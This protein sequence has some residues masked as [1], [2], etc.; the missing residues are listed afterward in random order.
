MVVAMY[1]P[2]QAVR[3][4]PASLLR[5]VLGVPGV[6]GVFGVLFLTGALATLGGCGDKTTVVQ[7]VV[8]PDAGVVVERV[9]C[10]SDA[11]CD[12][13]LFCD[14]PETC[15]AGVCGAG[16]APVC[17]DGVECTRDRCSEATRACVY[18]AADADADGHADANCQDADGV[19]LGDDCDDGD[20][21]R[22]PGNV[23]V[24][25]AQ[26]HD[27]DCDASTI[28]MRDVDA[29]TY[30]DAMCCNGE[31]C[32]SD[33]D[34]MNPNVHPSQA[35][36]CDGFDNNCDGV[37]DEGLL[38]MM[39]RDA[40]GDHVGDADG[41]FVAVC[42]GTGGY[43][44][45][46]ADCDDG[47]RRV[48]PNINELCSDGVDNDCDGEVDETGP[49]STW[50]R[51][52]DGD[53]FGDDAVQ[54]IVS[55]EVQAG[56]TLFPHDCNDLNPLV[57]PD[58]VEVCNG[59][60]DDCN[61]DADF[62]ISA[63]NGEDD[64]RDG[65]ADFLCGGALPD[66]DDREPLTHP[67]APELCDMVD[68]DCNGV[69]DGEDGVFDW[70]VD[71]DADGFGALAVAVSSCER[72][73][74]HVTVTGD[75]ADNDPDTHP[76]VPDDCGGRPQWDDDCDGEADEAAGGLTYYADVDQDG[77][78]AGEA[79]T[80]C[81]MPIGW[82]RS[83]GDCAP[84]DASI[85]PARDEVCTPGQA[86][87]DD[88]D[89]RVDCLDA[90]CAGEAACQAMFLLSR[91][92]PV[93]PLA[94]FPG[95]EA[96]VTVRLT[97]QALDAVPNR[98]LTILAPPGAIAAGGPFMTDGSGEVTFAMTAPLALGEVDFWVEA[99][100]ALPLRLSLA[101]IAPSDDT[102]FTVAN[103]A[104]TIGA[105]VPGP[106]MASPLATPDHIEVASDGTAYITDAGRKQVLRVSP[107]GE[108]SLIA[109]SGVNASTGSGGPATAAALQP[110]RTVLDEARQRLYVQ[111]SRTVRVIE[112]SQQP[113][114]IYDV[115]QGGGGG[116]GGP[117]NQAPADNII[118]IAL[119]ANGDLL[120]MNTTGIYRVVAETGRY[121]RVL[122]EATGSCT[123]SRPLA[124]IEGRGMRLRADGSLWIWGR[125][126]GGSFSIGNQAT[127]GI[128]RVVGDGALEH[129]AGSALGEAIVGRHRT[130]FLLGVV[131][132]LVEDAS[133]NLYFT[134]AGEIYRIDNNLGRITR[135]VGT[136]TPG[137]G[138][139]YVG[140]AA[141]QL[142]GAAGLAVGPDQRLWLAE[143][144]SHRVRVLWNGGRSDPSV[145]GLTVQQGTGQ[146]V[147]PSEVTAP[148]VVEARD[149]G[150]Q[151]LGELPVSFEA[152]DPSAATSGTVRTSVDFGRASSTGYA[153]GAVGD[154]T[155]TASVL[156]ITGGTAA[157][158]DFDVTV[159]RPP[160]GSVTTLFNGAHTVDTTGMSPD[161]TPAIVG[162]AGGV[163]GIATRADG[164]IYLANG[165]Q[166]GC[167]SWAA[168]H[169]Y[170]ID[171]DGRTRIV[172]GTASGGF[173]T[174]LGGPA[175]G[176]GLDI[177]GMLGWDEANN[178]LFVTTLGIQG[179]VDNLLVI[180]MDDG[181][182]D[183]VVGTLA[184]G[185]DPTVGPDGRVY[186]GSAGAL[187]AVDPDADTPTLE[188]WV[189]KGNCADTLAINGFDGSNGYETTTGMTAAFLPD[190]TAYVAT[191]VCG[192]EVE[193]A[194]WGIVHVDA[195][196]S[197]LG[198]VAGGGAEAN[199]GGGPI[200]ARE[201]QLGKLAG[202]HFDA[203]GDLYFLEQDLNRL[204]K[205]TVGGDIEHLAGDAGGAAGGTDFVPGPSA[206]LSGPRDIALLPDGS[207]LIS[208][209][210]NAAIRRYWQ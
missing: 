152:S 142:D 109:G 60:D 64:D 143:R 191:Q 54:T 197:L 3:V 53:D 46:A 75:C 113:P 96:A 41:T 8:S 194:G 88:C 150:G 166:Y 210:G 101:V 29:D 58:A 171:A 121:E 159:V 57:N 206:R 86:V 178:R 136:G 192:T 21:G 119:E 30:V 79:F 94:L 22:F 74:G 97:S 71:A 135:H 148:Q 95:A 176:A 49:P 100:D 45:E 16:A 34:D 179:S 157:A 167:C 201:A 204:R 130:D 187:Y 203:A 207:V 37:A 208:D 156:N 4:T 112:L 140:R 39:V 2:T 66:C 114:M 186:W 61:G 69:V 40:D 27:E 173:N 168:N 73:P 122:A 202:L 108:L 182:L 198:L 84:G 120:V 36:V 117:A 145:V 77:V 126:C 31:T 10:A 196:G 90:D 106:S 104:G 19:I 127:E 161:G 180:D 116:A 132:D 18:T 83:T 154:H 131:D 169:V 52:V 105:V 107:Q 35:E 183:A 6:P 38:E 164:T 138:A 144:T 165:N 162:R 123:P 15:R 67:G 51:D 139:E 147:W 82:V 190:G 98:P 43:E 129:V 11:D 81:Q 85:S 146:T 80:S 23:E 62:L 13:G 163:H 65:F 102:V 87:D 118:D 170:A 20:P 78:G 70:Y 137:T 17:D 128:F 48:N 93:E 141:A 44:P 72:Q 133:G 149:G 177:A 91:T 103:R 174:P 7:E 188:P 189:V 199:V 42:P 59:R 200:A 195:G 172:A 33:C 92:L 151:L 193:R 5:G 153:P 68:N 160:A 89:G 12:N 155:V 26:G 125:M 50:Y 111:E 175:V 205:L 115:T 209:R 56:Y 99:G 185:A 28:G 124:L 55:C 158:V 134:R 24:C 110:G 32:G 184:P 181:Y 63:G 25:D 14:G 9:Q 76:G 47:N 1:D